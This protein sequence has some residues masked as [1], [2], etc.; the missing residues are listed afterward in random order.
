MSASSRGHP[1]G[2]ARDGHLLIGAYV[3]G[4]AGLL[5]GVGF[6]LP[7][8]LIAGLTTALLVLL[9]APTRFRAGRSTSTFARSC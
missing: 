1:G 2:A 5:R 7:Q 3:V 4:A 6:P 8:L 9:R